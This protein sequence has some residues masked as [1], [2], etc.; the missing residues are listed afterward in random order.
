LRKTQADAYRAGVSALDT[1][2]RIKT[3]GSSVFTGA[4]K[5]GVAWQGLKAFMAKPFDVGIGQTVNDLKQTSGEAFKFVRIMQGSGVVSNADLEIIQDFLS[6]DKLLQ[7]KEGFKYRTDVLEKVAKLAL[8][9]LV[10]GHQFSPDEG[11]TIPWLKPSN[12]PRH[13]KDSTGREIPLKGWE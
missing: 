6:N 10:K 3:L 5:A 8:W 13:P 1:V 9:R 11:V 7:S 12:L 4:S 2:N